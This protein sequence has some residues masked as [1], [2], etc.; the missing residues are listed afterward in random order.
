MPSSPAG[1]LREVAPLRPS[2][3][4]RRL[5][6]ELARGFVVLPRH[7]QAAFGELVRVLAAAD[8]GL[9]REEDGIGGVGTP[10]PSSRAARDE[11]DG[12]GALRGTALGVLLSVPVWAWMALKLREAL[13]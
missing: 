9:E 3:Q 6:L 2:P 11:Y 12:R 13:G 5:L 4:P 8:A 10:G 7:E 1:S